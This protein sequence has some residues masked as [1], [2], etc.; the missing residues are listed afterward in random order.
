MVERGCQCID[1]ETKIT[2]LLI[3]IIR[4]MGWGL[5]CRGLLVVSVVVMQLMCVVS[6]VV[7][8]VVECAQDPHALHGDDSDT[9]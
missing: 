4:R 5:F 1:C 6:I 9:Q 7:G 3:L 2:V 8:E